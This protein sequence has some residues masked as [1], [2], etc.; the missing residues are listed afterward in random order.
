MRTEIIMKPIIPFALALTLSAPVFAQ[1]GTGSTTVGSG[2][3]AVSPALEAYT[4]S[5]IVG[6]LWQRDQLSPRD[7]S[8]VTVAALIARSH[9]ADLGAE[10]ERALAN[11]VTS[12]EISEIVTHLAF[13]AGWGTALAAAPIIADVFT[14]QGVSAGDL[15][16]LDVELLPQDAQGEAARVRSVNGLLGD[17]APGLGEFTTDPLFSDI[18]LRPDLDPR[19]RSLVTITSLIS[20]GQT[21]QLAGHLNR[22]LDNGLTSEE[23]GE[24]VAHLAFYSGWPTAFSAGPIVLEVLESRAQ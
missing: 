12:V 18:W 3:S 4:E 7:R 2:L 24:V 16:G 19:D 20:L 14:A 9:T 15:P 22:A 17:A 1:E 6:D 10:V 5:V 21:G 11:G 23:A 13:Y 8:I